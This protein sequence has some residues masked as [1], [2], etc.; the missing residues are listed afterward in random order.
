VLLGAG[1]SKNWHGWL[2]EEVLNRLL[3]CP[4]VVADP[5]LRQI[6]WSASD[7]GF[8]SAL[9]HVQDEAERDPPSESKQRR[10][11]AMQ[12]A[13]G[14]V[15]REMNS[16]FLNQ[17]TFESHKSRDGTVRGFLTR[18]HA[19]FTLNQDVL[20]EHHYHDNFDIGL[21]RQQ[22]WNSMQI[23]GMRRLP[24]N[25]PLFDKSWARAQWQPLPDHEYRIE[26]RSQPYI[27][28]HGSS[29]WVPSGGNPLLIIGGNK[30]KA[31]Q[32][33]KILRR[34]ALEFSN[35]LS[36]P[37]TRLMIIGYGFKDHHVNRAINKAVFEQGLQI[38]I[39]SPQGR[40]L[41]QVFSSN[42][43]KGIP[44]AVYGYDL[45]AMFAKG[46]IGISEEPLRE[47][48]GAASTPGRL[49]V[50]SLFNE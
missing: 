11:Q 7:S 17:S 40:R 45:E 8:E 48:F 27:K 50:M 24:V 29:N 22:C 46:V 41:A 47:T 33:H 39:I 43:H 19:I 36:E 35:R 23:P 9:E 42:V 18:F 28:L 13:V 4:E 2:A 20:L 1:F 12:G 21:E 37:N 26:Q 34:Y 31:I 38:F 30:D 44:L 32:R 10:L 16:A 5:E 3:G 15:F 49:N 25:E 6:L 14:R